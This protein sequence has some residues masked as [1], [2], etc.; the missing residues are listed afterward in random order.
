ML[1][2]AGV[3]NATMTGGTSQSDARTNLEVCGPFHQLRTQNEAWRNRPVSRL[4]QSWALE[5]QTIAGL[6]VADTYYALV[7]TGMLF[8]VGRC[9]RQ[10]DSTTHSV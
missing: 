10:V 2:E 9:D 5:A 1:L 8:N 4:T 3:E 7:S 6:P